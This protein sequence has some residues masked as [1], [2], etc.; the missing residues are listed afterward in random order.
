MLN[1]VARTHYFSAGS[2]FINTETLY[3]WGCELSTDQT[4][5]K[6]KNN[7]DNN[8]WYTIQRS[9]PGLVKLTKQESTL[10]YSP[11]ILLWNVLKHSDI[12]VSDGL[13]YTVCSDVPLGQR[14]PSLSEGVCWGCTGPPS[15]GPKEHSDGRPSVYTETTLLNVYAGPLPYPSSLFRQHVKVR[16]IG[17]R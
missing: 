10:W 12:L 15:S 6:R 13:R 7:Y 4:S 1:T 17:G 14:Q 9:C 8:N 11:W 3:F 5:R 2:P 16:V